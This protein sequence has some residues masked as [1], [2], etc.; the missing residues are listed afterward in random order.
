MVHSVML[1]SVLASAYIIGS[2]ITFILVDKKKVTWQISHH[3]SLEKEPPSP[4]KSCSDTLKAH[5]SYSNIYTGKLDN[6]VR[7]LG[8]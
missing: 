1:G 4:G 3:D 6:G 2:L 7:G 5:K 8:E